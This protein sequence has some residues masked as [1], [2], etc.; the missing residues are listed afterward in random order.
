MIQRVVAMMAAVL[1]LPVMMSEAMMGLGAENVTA[2]D[3]SFHVSECQSAQIK[4]TCFVHD[5]LDKL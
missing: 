3:H 1:S 5:Y 2:D 4:V